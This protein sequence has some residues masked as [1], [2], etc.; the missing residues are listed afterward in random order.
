MVLAV[1]LRDSPHGPDLEHQV[2]VGAGFGSGFAAP[3]ETLGG[4]QP[5]GRMRR[6]FGCA[7][8]TTASRVKPLTAAHVTVCELL[9]TPR[10]TAGWIHDDPDRSLAP[11]S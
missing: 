11:V 10:D 9:W 5:P 2:P 1:F 3:A 6:S 8:I 7:V 4:R